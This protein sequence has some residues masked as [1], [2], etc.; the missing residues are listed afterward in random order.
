MNNDCY[1]WLI[2]G[3]GLKVIIERRGRLGRESYE[4]REEESGGGGRRLSVR[5]Q[6]EQKHI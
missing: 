1:V 2:V 5:K 4:G 3:E 6:F